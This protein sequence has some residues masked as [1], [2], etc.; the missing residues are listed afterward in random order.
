MAMENTS[1][2]SNIDY[3]IDQNDIDYLMDRNDELETGS[4]E[5][6]SGTNEIFMEIAIFLTFAFV[7]LI[8]LCFYI[9]INGSL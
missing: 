7:F 9:I 6:R 4:F 8:S 5:L 3:V 1:P 2:D